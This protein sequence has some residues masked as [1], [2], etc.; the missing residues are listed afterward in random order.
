MSAVAIGTS[1]IIFLPFLLSL[2]GQSAQARMLCLISSVLGLLLSVEEYGAVMPW[3]LGMIV[4]AASVW[5]RV[6]QRR[7]A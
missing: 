6:R 7:M 3:V 5:E 2:F 1:L 4:A